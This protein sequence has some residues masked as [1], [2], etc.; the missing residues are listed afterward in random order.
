MQ[1]DKQNPVLE[2][3]SAFIDDELPAAEAHLLLARLERDEHLRAACGTYHL[4]GEC[5]R[6]GLAAVHARDLCSRVMAAL[7][8]EP[9]P[10]PVQHLPRWLKTGSGL[11]V[12]ATVAVVA[13]LGLQQQAGQ[14]LPSEVVPAMAGT[15]TQVNYANFRPASW[16]Q[17]QPE[18]QSQLN[19]Y[20]LQHNEHVAPQSVQGML[21]YVHIAAYNLRS[22]PARDIQET[23]NTRDAQ[24]LPAA[25]EHT[26][27]EPPR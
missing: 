1:D 20:L 25:A 27:R 18:V 26:D 14:S 8:S 24:P 17:A 5:L 7:D 21:P 11:A 19:R 23:R 4:T 13:I 6:G 2:Q 22:V 12:A 10:T 3:L 16:S 9:A 15:D